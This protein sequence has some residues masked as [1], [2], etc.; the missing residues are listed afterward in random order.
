MKKLEFTQRKKLEAI[1]KETK[2]VN[3]RVRICIVLAFDE[4]YSHEAI[5]AAIPASHFSPVSK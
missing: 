1:V 5:T 4:G 3:E 2:D